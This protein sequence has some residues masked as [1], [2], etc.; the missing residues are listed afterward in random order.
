ME[1]KKE[2]NPIEVIDPVGVIQSYK[3][4]DF[5]TTT[6]PFD[7]L[8]KFKKDKFKFAQYSRL[9]QI[10]AKEVEI[11][12]FT[13]LY[14]NYEESYH[15]EIKPVYANFTEFDGQPLQLAS[16]KYICTDDVCFECKGSEI[17]EVCNHPI[18]P[19]ERLVNIDDNTEKLKLNYRKGF[20]WR[21]IIVDKEMLASA[22]KIVS[23][24]KYGIAVNS[25]NAR[26]LVRYLTDIE[27]LNFDTIE[28]KSSVGR[29]GWIGN[30]GFSPYVND[31]VFD[32]D[33][34]FRGIFNS[35]KYSGNIEEWINFCKEIRAEKNICSR[36]MLAASFSSVLVSPCDCLPFFVHLWGGT[37]SGKT[38]ALMLAASVWASPSLGDY[39]RTFNTTAVAQE[40]TAGFV[41]SLPL[42]YDELQIIKKEASHD[43]IVYKLCEGIG[44]DR[45]KKSGGV[46][47]IL[48]WRNCILT[49]GEYP[50]SNATSGAGAVNRIIEI[51]CKDQK[52]FKD[53]VKVV[54]KIKNN[55]GGAGEVFVK[56]LQENG[57]I[58][59]VQKIRLK[60][61]QAFSEQSDVTDKQA[62][63][64]SLILTADELIERLFFNDGIRLTVDEIKPFLVTK[65]DVNQNKRCYDF[66]NDFIVANYNRFVPDEDGKYT[67]EIWGDMTSN[68]V[69]I[70][71]SK[72][73]KILYDNGFN[74]R[75]F[76]SW[77]DKNGLIQRSK[78]HLTVTR[79]ILGKGCRCVCLLN[80][81]Q[82][83]SVT[84]KDD[85]PF[86]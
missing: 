7:F 79:R 23:L 47:K 6:I 41:N 30:H 74:A 18:M 29:L 12:N 51:D 17:E 68:K 1:S 43:D 32:G 77:A 84:S 31:L 35:V 10:R 5:L 39:I 9:M 4:D 42:C 62:M 49:T 73:D 11:T 2:D 55:Y 15:Q 28:E 20:V 70:I 14:K 8:Y 67:G 45:G 75:A 37:E 52:I 66:L 48:T 44:R 83:E 76:L 81:S 38:V 36:I 80:D 82:N 59:K 3:K 72:F 21:E 34:S 63:S 86:V 46:Q 69:Y 50:I 25:E 24:A 58:E 85:M 53:P 71:K 56:W 26:N 16:G 33:E 78:D 61:N 22:N 40:L 27:N 57:N 54:S 13:G 64:A 19:V 65:N 60:Y